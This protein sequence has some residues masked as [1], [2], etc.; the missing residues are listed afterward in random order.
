[1]SMNLINL[2]LFLSL[3]LSLAR[4]QLVEASKQANERALLERKEKVMLELAK[5]KARVDEFNDYGELDMMQQYVM[6]VR[7]VQKRLAD[8]QQEIAWINKEEVGGWV[9]GKGGG[10]KGMVVKGGGQTT[11]EP[12]STRRR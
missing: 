10:W 1:M 9:Y 8:A 7:A 2:P 5:L 12:G 11:G 3:S 4:T 6:D